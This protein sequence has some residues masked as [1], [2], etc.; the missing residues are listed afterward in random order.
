MLKLGEYNIN[1]DYIK[2]KENRIA[3]FLT[4]INVETKEIN[5]VESESVNIP[6]PENSESS[7]E[8]SNLSME[9][10]IDEDVA[11]TIHSQ[12]ENLNNHIPI[13]DSI[14]NRFKIQIIL[15]NNKIKEFEMKNK[16]KKIYINSEDLQ[17]NLSDILRRHV[18]PGKIGI[19]TELSDKEYNIVQGKIIELFDGN[20]K[21]KFVRCSFHA[22]DINNEEEA[23]KQIHKYH[24]F[25]T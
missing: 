13:L 17:N 9:N 15:T 14:V 6:I 1:I 25:E 7:E 3:D 23:F 5:V 19:Y 21:I 11:E 24:K 22:K 16:S 12:E 8:L 2:G 20:N 18:K 10:N 4:R